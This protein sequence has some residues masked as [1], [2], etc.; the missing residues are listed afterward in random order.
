[1]NIFVTDLNPIQAAWNLDDKRVKH[2]PKE[3]LELLACY[4]HSVTDNWLIPFPLW[5]DDTRTEPM[6]L[7]NNPISK[8]VRKDRANVFWLY[9]HTLALFEEHQY[10]FDSINPVQHFLE[11]MKPF[12]VDVNRQPKAFQNSS[13]YKQLYIVDAYRQTMMNKWLLTDKIKPITWT[14]RGQ[15]AWF[16]KQLE[17]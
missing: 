2:M 7:Y 12:M 4:I 1:M 10:R 14:K 3:C 16:N 5:G 15:P 8:W 13:L 6:F 11:D 9:R 17:L